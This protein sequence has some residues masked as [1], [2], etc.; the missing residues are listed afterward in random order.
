MAMLY[1]EELELRL[2]PLLK[3]LEPTMT[4][5]AQSLYRSLE[6]GGVW[7]LFGSG[8]SALLAEEAF[9]R[10]GGLVPVNTLTELELSPL[11][12]PA[13]NR[14]N[15]RAAGKAES[16]LGKHDLRSGEVIWI[17]SNSGINSVSVD[18]ALSA[19]AKGLEV[20]AITS[21][22]HS[23]SQHSRHESGKRLFEVADH[24]IDTQL[25]A[26]DVLVEHQGAD[27]TYGAGAAS[28]VVGSVILHTIE[29]KVIE[30]Y[31]QAGSVPPIYISSNMAGGDE[32]NKKLEAKYAQRILR[33]KEN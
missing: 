17:I 2:G 9:H 29:S 19:K 11:V 33:F 23:T 4:V 25:P 6:Q 24:T 7:H 12:N 27:V 22:K 21:V 15:E 10:A 31:I 28:L 14:E 8:H 5:A 1:W 18:M 16:I 32:H 26:G 20:W 30:R 13:V 3:G